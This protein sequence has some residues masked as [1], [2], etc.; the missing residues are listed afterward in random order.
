MATDKLS[1][2]KKF[3]KKN[4][5]LPS[6]AEMLHLFGFASKKSIFDVVRKWIEQGFLKKDGRNIAPT[7]KFFALP[8]LGFVKAGFPIIADEDKKYLTLDEFL[9]GDPTSTFLFTVRGDSLIEAGIFEGDIVV[10]ERKREAYPG[11]IV[12]AIIDTEWTLKILRRNREKRTL[13]LEAANRRY[14]A[15]YP[16]EE[17]KIFGVVK[18][19]VRK[20][21]N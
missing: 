20:L 9:I 16:R 19:V 1:Q 4:R 18:A 11:D 15:F 17:L 12:L 8:V 7:S 2:I 13:Y 14:P 21:K 3:Y 6:Y 5:R 10:I